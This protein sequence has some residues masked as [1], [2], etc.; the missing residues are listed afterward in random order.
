ME[1]I[2]SVS[3]DEDDDGSIQTKGRSG[4]EIKNDIIE[5]HKRK[6]LIV[7]FDEVDA[8]AE[9]SDNFL[10]MF[11]ND[12]IS[13]FLI[14][15]K[16]NWTDKCDERIQ[17]RAQSNRIDFL[18]YSE[19]QIVDILKFIA[20]KGLKEGWIDDKILERIAHLTRSQFFSD[21]RKGKNLMSNSVNE[22]MKEDKDKVTDEHVQKALERVRPTSIAQMLQNFSLSV[23][24]ALAGYVSQQLDEYEK[25]DKVPATTES[26]Y[27][28]FQTCWKANG[29]EGEPV[30]PT[31]MKD[32]LKH[33]GTA[34]ILNPPDYK[35]YQTR[36]R[37]N[38]YDSEYTPKELAEAL[39]EKGVK[40]GMRKTLKD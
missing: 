38:F 20:N 25:R 2:P 31:M 17:S 7:V 11:F 24:V 34:G 33:L 12:K 19:P 35:S 18:P 27:V 40:L 23:L 39:K 8:L 3:F 36:G 4:T 1:R 21:M 10:Y 28:F 16:L 22:A 29:L 15:N 32:Y 14:S 6:P 26:I 5:R 37:T 9:V 13:Q 30:T